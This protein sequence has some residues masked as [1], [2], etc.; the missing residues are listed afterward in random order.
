M[1]QATK[2][3]VFALVDALQAHPKDLE[4]LAVYG[5]LPQLL[6]EVVDDYDDT[7]SDTSTGCSA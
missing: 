3:A 6:L 1:Q 7:Q 2:E 5:N 4:A